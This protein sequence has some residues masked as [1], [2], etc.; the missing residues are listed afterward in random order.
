MS[1]L[2]RLKTHR[3]TMK[4]FSVM[5]VPMGSIMSIYTADGPAE[6]AIVDRQPSQLGADHVYLLF[7]NGAA[8]PY[9]RDATV[10]AFPPLL[11]GEQ[12]VSDSLLDIIH[13]VEADEVLEVLGRGLPVAFGAASHS[14]T[15]L[16]ARLAIDSLP[17]EQWLAVVEYMVR[18]QNLA[19]YKIVKD[20]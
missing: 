1:E 12:P 11:P 3:A 10:H 2:A 20:D 7:A 17:H 13:A 14:R 15:A 6:V 18:G 8:S 9:A 16:A 5:E 19:G 4:G